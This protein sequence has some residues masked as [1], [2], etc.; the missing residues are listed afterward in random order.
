VYPRRPS[1]AFLLS[2]RWLGLGA[3]ALAL[4]VVMVG[5]GQWQLDRYHQRSEINARID[6]AATAR[7]TPVEQ[8]LPPAAPRGGPPPSAAAGWTRVTV[9]GEYDAARELLVR[10][11]TV[12][13]RVGFEVLTPLRLPDGSAILV[14]RGW[15]PPAPSGLSA[16]PDV[17]AVPGGQVIAVGLIHLSESHA[18]RVDRVRG[19]PEVRRIGIPSIARE[20]PYPVYGAYLLLDEQTPAADPRLVPVPAER[21]NAVQNLGYVIQWWLFAAIT[22]VGFG[23]LARREGRDRSAPSDRARVSA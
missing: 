1:Y 6:A 20:L 5:L 4:A 7:P 16:R 17:P 18:G 11:R 19:Q 8:V 2:P 15:V 23:M 22:L 9:T 10:N 13:S 14:D 21:Q 3:L 12:Q